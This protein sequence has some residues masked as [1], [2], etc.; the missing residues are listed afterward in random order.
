MVLTKL[1]W[2]ALWYMKI[3]YIYRAG[4]NLVEK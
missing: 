4:D 1:A 3:N 2:A